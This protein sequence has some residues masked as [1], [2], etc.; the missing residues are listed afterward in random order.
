MSLKL[1][2]KIK[3]IDTD[4]IYNKLVKKIKAYNPDVDDQLLHKAY[5][6]SK[7]DHQNQYR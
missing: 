4:L 1:S 2:S 5:L 3:N 6:I 7:K